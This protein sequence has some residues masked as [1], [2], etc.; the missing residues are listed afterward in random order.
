MVI[1]VACHYFYRSCRMLLWSDRVYWHNVPHA[2]PHNFGPD[3]RLLLPMS[4]LTAPFTDT[5]RHC[6]KDY[7]NSHGIPVGIITALIGAP[8]FLYVL[9]TKKRRYSDVKN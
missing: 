2:G 5:C 1:L 4:M 6:I 9:R 3:Y 7:F 8:F